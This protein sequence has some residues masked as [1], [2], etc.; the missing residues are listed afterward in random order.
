MG[1]G[2]SQEQSGSLTPLFHHDCENEHEEGDGHQETQDETGGIDEDSEE[3]FPGN[4]KTR[5]NSWSY[6]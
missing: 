3:D 2:T 1:E 4:V 6:S 5:D